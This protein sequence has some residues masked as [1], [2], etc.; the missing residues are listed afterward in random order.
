MKSLKKTI[1]FSYKFKGDYKK[2]L[3]KYEKTKD[4]NEFKYIEIDFINNISYVFKIDKYI[5]DWKDEKYEDIKLRIIKNFLM[6]LI[7]FEKEKTIYFQDINKYEEIYLFI[8]SYIASKMIKKINNFIYKLMNYHSNYI[9]YGDHKEK[10]GS[11]VGYIE[12]NK[13]YL[14]KKIVNYVINI[15]KKYPFISSSYTI[16]TIGFKLKKR[17]LKKLN[18]Y[19]S[20]YLYQWK[21]KKMFSKRKMLYQIKR[22]IEDMYKK[23]KED[24]L[25]KRKKIR[26]TKYKYSF[27]KEKLKIINKC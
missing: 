18:N 10:W 9:I 5:K 16:K 3:L 23:R 20:I 1:N 8:S 6:F 4:I 21:V 27:Q 11:I 25:E 2:V 26:H 14:A 19:R 17:E 13:E 7:S 24:M 15:R 12:T 22:K